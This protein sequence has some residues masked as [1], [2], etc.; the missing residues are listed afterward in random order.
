MPI[1]AR[2]DICL[3][4]RKVINNSPVIIQISDNFIFTLVSINGINNI[5][6]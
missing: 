1:I 4:D 2:K 5:N 6:K 3:T